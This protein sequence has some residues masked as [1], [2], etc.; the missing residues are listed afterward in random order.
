M[1]FQRGALRYQTADHRNRRD[2]IRTGQQRSR[3]SRSSYNHPNPHRTSVPRPPGK[4][5][6]QIRSP[7]SGRLAMLLKVQDRET[8]LLA[9][10]RKQHL[11]QSP[12]PSQDGSRRIGGRSVQTSTRSNGHPRRNV[13][14]KGLSRGLPPRRNNR[15]STTRRDQSESTDWCRFKV[16]LFRR[17]QRKAP[18]HTALST[19]LGRSCV[20]VFAAAE[21]YE[22]CF[23][24]IFRSERDG[25][26]IN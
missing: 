4:Q 17:S 6:N 26:P 8:R 24:A 15:R 16:L 22:S 25:Y 13:L 14:R 9:L 21:S 12:E 20:C 23:L 10:C 7:S 2:R 18:L 11:F 5:A 1:Q 19:S 3:S